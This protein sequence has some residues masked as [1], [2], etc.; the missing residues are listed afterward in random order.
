MT[1]QVALLYSVVLSP[2]RRVKS[3]E[4]VEIAK[5]AGLGDP[6][7]VLSTGNLVFRSHRE[8]QD[9]ESALEH[10]IQSRLG[11]PVAVFVR[12]A[13]A[14]RALIDANPVPAETAHDPARVAVRI[15]R[16]PPTVENLQ[17]IA[18][19]VGSGERFAATGRALWVAAADS[20]STSRLLRAVGSPWVGEGTLR[21]VS[22]IGKIAG[23]L[24]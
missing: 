11:K 23:M 1:R 13:D 19:T 21:S 8:E 12:S 17:R 6:R 9:L 22:A 4:L 14:W 16:H 3:A 7:T 24:D 5:L 20:R 18:D 2:V 15:M 10:L